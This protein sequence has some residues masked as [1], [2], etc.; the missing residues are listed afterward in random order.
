[1]KYKLKLNKRNNNNNDDVFKQYCDC[2]Y[3]RIY[4]YSCNEITCV[5]SKWINYVGT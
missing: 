5:T 2:I 4:S 3:M 1:M